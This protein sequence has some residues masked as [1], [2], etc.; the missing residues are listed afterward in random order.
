MRKISRQTL[1]PIAL[2]IENVVLRHRG[3]SG[4]LPAT[5]SQQPTRGR[6][7]S[8]PECVGRSEC[9][10]IFAR[11]VDRVMLW[12]DN[13]LLRLVHEL[14]GAD[15]H[16]EGGEERIGLTQVIERVQRQR[17]LGRIRVQQRAVFGGFMSRPGL[18]VRRKGVDDETELSAHRRP[19]ECDQV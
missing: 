2:H 7:C 6:R 19:F 3:G 10:R 16:R 8:I 18:V 14:I 11:V 13:Q 17:V 15:E 9:R 12:V 1:V 4:R 5:P